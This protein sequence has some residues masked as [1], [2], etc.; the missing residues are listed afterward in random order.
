MGKC[1]EFKTL[2][3]VYE[4]MNIAPNDEGQLMLNITIVV[5]EDVPGPL[6]VLIINKFILL[7]SKSVFFRFYRWK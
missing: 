3:I 7:I 5:Y 6:R 4:E 1:P 2:P